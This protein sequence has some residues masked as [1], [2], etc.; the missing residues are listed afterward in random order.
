MWFDVV[1]HKEERNQAICSQRDRLE[2]SCIKQGKPN[3]EKQILQAFSHMQNL[4]LNRHKDV[5]SHRQTQM[6]QAYI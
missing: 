1:S 4:D 3:L 6:M 2:D 5:G